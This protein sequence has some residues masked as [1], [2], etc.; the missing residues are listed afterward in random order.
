MKTYLTALAI[1]AITLAAPTAAHSECVNFYGEPVKCIPVVPPT[2]PTHPEIEQKMQQL[3]REDRLNLVGSELAFLALCT[4]SREEQFAFFQKLAPEIDYVKQKDGEGWVWGYRDW[5]MQKVTGQSM[6][7]I[8]G[9]TGVAVNYPRQWCA[10][11]R[12]AI[13]ATQKYHLP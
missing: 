11:M 2:K 8:N 9:G 3:T 13:T 7:V 12:P 4:D 6:A 5:W 10:E 1:A